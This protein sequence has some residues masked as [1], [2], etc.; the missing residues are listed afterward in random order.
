MQYE[1]EIL[2]KLK[3]TE[4]EILCEIIRICDKYGINWF[5]AFGT[6]IGVERHG[7]F[8]PWDDDM[9]IAMLRDDFEKFCEVAKEEFGEKYRLVNNFTDK[10]YACT[11]THVIKTG[12]LFLS[13]DDK[14]CKFKNGINVDIF[15]FDSVSDDKKIAEKQY[16]KA[17]LYGRLLFL[18]GEGKP[19]LDFGGIKAFLCRVIFKAV[20]IC[21]CVFGVTKRKLY[22]KL[23]AVSS[24][25]RDE[26]TELV[27]DFEAPIAR[28]ETIKREWIFPLKEKTFEGITVKVPNR[29]DLVLEKQYGDY[30][31]L[32]PEDKRVS[33]RPYLVDFGEEK[34]NA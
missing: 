15:V 32:P 2:E 12:T 7:G 19:H 28:A 25:C 23:V 27:A 3:K 31:Q 21:L 18:R 29:N 10:E 8:I 6:A 26:E 1:P 14:D 22:K 30:M 9:D 17:W 11:V 13:E 16:K 24:L 20:H 34:V 4:V 33:H 5:A